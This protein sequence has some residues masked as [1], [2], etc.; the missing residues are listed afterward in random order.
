MLIIADRILGGETSALIINY[1]KVFLGF[2]HQCN[3]LILG[4]GGYRFGDY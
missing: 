4:P 2:G 1:N 3:A